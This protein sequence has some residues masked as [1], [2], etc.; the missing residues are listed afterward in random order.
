MG[1]FVVVEIF[2]ELLLLFNTL[3]VDGHDVLGFVVVDNDDGNGGA[4]GIVVIVDVLVTI[5]ATL[6][7]RCRILV[8]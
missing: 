6:E 3:D 7:V 8:T 5:F 2:N 1:L 4:S